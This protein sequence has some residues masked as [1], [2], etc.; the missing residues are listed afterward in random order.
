M[1][2]C[3]LKCLPGN[4]VVICNDLYIRFYFFTVYFSAQSVCSLSGSSF[5]IQLKSL[6]LF[7]QVFLNTLVENLLKFK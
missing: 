1:L 3:E 6:S 7:L 2:A 4:F 5:I